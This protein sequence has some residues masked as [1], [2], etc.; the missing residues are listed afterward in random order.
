MPALLLVWGRGPEW[1]VMLAKARS[2][3]LPQHAPVS[4]SQ[5][6][7]LHKVAGRALDRCP[8]YP[9]RRAPNILLSSPPS[10][11]SGSAAAA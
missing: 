11:S 7:Q 6:M 4:L 5:R 10:P 1:L 9:L 8:I 3:Q 2:N